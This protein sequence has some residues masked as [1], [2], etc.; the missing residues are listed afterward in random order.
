[1]CSLVVFIWENSGCLSL[2]LSCTTRLYMCL[3]WLAF[4][5]FAVAALAFLE[6]FLANLSACCICESVSFCV[7][8]RVRGG[9]VGSFLVSISPRLRPQRDGVARGRMDAG[10]AVRPVHGARG[11]SPVAWAPSL[12]SALPISPGTLL[13]VSSVVTGA[14]LVPRMSA[15]RLGGSFLRLLVFCLSRPRSALGVAA[16]AAPEWC[17]RFSWG[18][19]PPPAAERRLPATLPHQIEWASEEV[20]V[21]VHSQLLHVR[22]LP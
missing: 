14:V 1:M 15:L 5:F 21:A 2:Y 19:D 10:G 17:L 20:P 22:I 16:W 13:W 8:V 11:A 6:T 9:G 7:L 12:R 3:P 4:C 18:V